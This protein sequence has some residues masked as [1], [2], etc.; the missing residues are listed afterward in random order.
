MAAAKIGFTI[1]GVSFS[2]EGEEA[3]LEKQLDKIIEK[4]PDLI[5]IAPRLTSGA[6]T[7][8][9]IKPPDVTKKENIDISTKTLSA[10]LKEKNAT[11]NQE[12][13]FL[14]TSIWLQAKG[15]SRIAIKDVTQA[16][17]D[18]NQKRL[19]NPSRELGKNITKGFIERDGQGFFVTEQGKE[20][21]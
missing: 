16:L 7:D 13:K 17:K 12:R 9:G 4:A 10:F 2:G 5:K 1:G 11:V 3:W 8:E 20:S 19:G 6:E 14:V 21:T 15:Q 18:S